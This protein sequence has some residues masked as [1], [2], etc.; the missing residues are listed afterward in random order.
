MPPRLL[1]DPSVKG[2]V[3]DLARSYGFVDTVHS[4]S[5]SG[6]VW[7]SNKF[8]NQW[9]AMPSL[10]FGYSLLIGLTV[11][12]LPLVSDEVYRAKDGSTWEAMRSTRPS[13]R[14]LLCIFCGILYPTVICFAVIAT[15]NHFMLDV[16]AG[17]A[18]CALG[19][20]G[21]RALL[22]LLPLEDYF[23][24][25]VRIHKPEVRPSWQVEMDSA[26][27]H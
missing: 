9:A 15:A 5:G 8:C 3:G 25:L 24:A 2:A 18:V 23:L 19:W 13:W 6:S 10:H 16:V 7:T 21:N 22:S 12:T 27:L 11:A 4:K 14:R 17:A 1:S 20:V 26:L